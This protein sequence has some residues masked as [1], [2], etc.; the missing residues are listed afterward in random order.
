MLIDHK[1]MVG[2][3]HFYG[4][5]PLQGVG[6]PPAEGV[7]RMSFLHYTTDAEVDQLIEGLDAAL[8]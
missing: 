6:I 5:R 7:L 3:G 2:I 4:V 8:G 1:L